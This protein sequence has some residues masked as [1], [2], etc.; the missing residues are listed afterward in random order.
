MAKE[1]KS[2]YTKEKDPRFSEQEITLLKSLNEDVVKLLRLVFHQRELTTEQGELLKNKLTADVVKVLKRFFIHEMNHTEP[3][4]SMPS[5]WNNP[6]FDAML[7]AEVRPIIQGRQLAI[8]FLNK[9]VSR[10]EK[11][12]Q[13]DTTPLEIKVDLEFTNDYSTK[14]PEEAK[15]AGVASQEAVSFLESALLAVYAYVMQDTEELQK[16]VARLKQNSAK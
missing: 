13:G 2:P 12:S 4:F 11:I 14:T 15:V 16:M 3:I 5:R 7:T 1:V 9:G 10:M 8:D 6:R